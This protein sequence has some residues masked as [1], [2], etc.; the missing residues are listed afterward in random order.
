MRAGARALQSK[1]VKSAK[2][3]DAEE[4]SSGFVWKE[5]RFVFVVV[6]SHAAIRINVKEGAFNIAKSDVHA[7]LQI[8]EVA[9]GQRE[10]TLPLHSSESSEARLWPRVQC[11][12]LPQA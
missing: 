7:A 2:E 8:A 6:F 12:C 9:Q 10:Y 11:W 4:G 5:A 1:Y 3:V